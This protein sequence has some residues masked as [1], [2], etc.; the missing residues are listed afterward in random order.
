MRARK[1]KKALGLLIVDFAII[2]GIFVIQFRN[3]SIINV[4]N[5]NLQFT[6]N[7]TL[8]ENNKNVLQDRFQLTFSG[9]SFFTD[10]AHPL[11]AFYKNEVEKRVLPLTAWK[12]VDEL[13]YSFTF[14]DEVNLIVSMTDTTENAAFS[15]TADLPEN[16]EKI[17][18]PY[19]IASTLGIESKSENQIIL[20]GKKDIWAFTADLF[21]DD[22]LTLSKAI[23]VASFDVYKETQ[24]NFT[25]ETIDELAP[26]AESNYLAVISA[27]KDNLISAFRTASE[28]Q[29]TE[30]AIVSYVAAMSEKGKYNQTIEEI[31]ASF[32][33]SAK[34]TYLSAPY[35]NSLSET[36]NTLT[37]TINTKNDLIRK[38]YNGNLE[39]LTEHN[40]A[41]FMYI[42]TGTA[43]VKAI[44]QMV[45]KLNPDTL[46][47]QQLAGILRLYVEMYPLSRNFVRHMEP[48]IPRI[49]EIIEKSCVYDKNV[50]TISSNG[51]FLSV[52]QA[53]EI[54]DA[55]MRYGELIEDRNLANS[56][57]LLIAS[58]MA[59]SSSFDFKTLGE[60]YPVLVHNN[61]FYPHFVKLNTSGDDVTW[62]WTCAM[63]ITFTKDSSGN[64]TMEIDFPEGSTHYVILRGVKPFNNIYIYN[65]D[66]RMAYDF[67]IYNSSGYLYKADSH[68]LLLKS[69]HKNQVEEVRLVHTAPKKETVATT[70]AAKTESVAETTESVEKTEEAPA[71]ESTPVEA[72]AL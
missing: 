40:M 10:E 36:N 52:I 50:L 47:L 69:R 44:M 38:A 63:D 31:P 62:A 58:Y 7:Q 29:M 57:K 3:D 32:K 35:F 71:E 42:Y 17:Q 59:E 61:T 65:M 5:G 14:G 16:I 55:L 21:E 20:N 54:G 13:T 68:S 45:G 4:K 60:I 25:F 67:E 9:L 1:F 11:Y 22:Y 39:F 53:I 28:S 51:S 49:L 46:T 27:F 6:L 56:G 33:K 64:E 12:K 48:V 15:L 8:D 19:K 66:F 37:T 43:Q 23:Q 41:S 18:L 72:P 26:E 24:K 70:T 34:R 30:Q 2:I